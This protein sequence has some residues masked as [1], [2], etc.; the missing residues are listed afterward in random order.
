MKG[1]KIDVS[2]ICFRLKSQKKVLQIKES[3]VFLFIIYNN[4]YQV[5]LNFFLLKLQIL[6]VM[7]QNS[8]NT[9]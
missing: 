1:K 5:M 6:M 3:G 2:E 9:F 8:N 7:F 4:T